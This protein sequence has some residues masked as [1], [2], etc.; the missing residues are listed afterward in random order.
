M[1]SLENTPD[2]YPFNPIRVETVLSRFPVHR[3]AK[4]GKIE[5]EI[6]ETDE[7]GVVDQVQLQVAIE[8]LPLE[9]PGELTL[10][11][12]DMQIGDGKRLADIDLPEGV[13]LLD[14]PESTVV[15]VYVPQAEV[16]ETAVDEEEA[17]EQALGEDGD[18]PADAGEAEATEEGGTDGGDS[19]SDS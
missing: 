1:E 11:I 15:S 3:L 13:E 17:L 2:L 12:S 4:K 19:D 8:L 16:P 5:I 14:D 18:V 10:D 9:V 7:G 6:T